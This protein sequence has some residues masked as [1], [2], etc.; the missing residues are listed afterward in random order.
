MEYQGELS[1]P[2]KTRRR[3]TSRFKAQVL[4]EVE[5][6][7]TSVAA[8]ARRHNL[9]ANLIHKWRKAA[10]SCKHLATPAF[11]ALPTLPASHEPARNE[12]RVEVPI[13]Q[14]TAT[15]YWPGNQPASLAEFIKRL[16]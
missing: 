5:E 7:G 15:L 2:V 13:N 1:V 9:N 14:G 6:P 10:A 8:V 4:S 16:S 3:H 12:V 11:V